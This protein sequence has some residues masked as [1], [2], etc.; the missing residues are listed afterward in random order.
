MSIILYSTEYEGPKL[1]LRNRSERFDIPEDIFEPYTKFLG[2]ALFNLI[3][4]NRVQDL[5]YQSIS[6]FENHN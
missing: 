5:T 3:K 6:T 1:E 2:Y 4:R